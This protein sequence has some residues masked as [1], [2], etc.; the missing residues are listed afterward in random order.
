ML[1]LGSL[2]VPM[3]DR[4]PL[5]TSESARQLCAALDAGAATARISVD[6]GR[7]CIDV[8]IVDGEVR[9]G[10]AALNRA[11]LQKIVGSPNQ[12]F[13]I[14]AGH[15]RAVSVFSRTTGW[16]RSL[17]PTADAPT[18]VVAG[19]PMH[20]IQA[21]TPLADTRAKVRALG[22]ARALRGSVLDT[23]TGL[24][25]TAIELAKRSTEVVTVE[26]DPAA[27]ELAQRNP[28]S[29]DLFTAENIRLVV[30][31]I[32]QEVAHFADAQFHAVLHDPPTVQLA[33]ELYSRAFYM[34]LRRVLRPNGRLFHYVGDPASVAGSRA[35][36]G[37]MRR[38]AEA[39]FRSVRRV[40]R[41]FGVVAVAGAVNE[42][43][44]DPRKRNARRRR[45]G[46]G[47]R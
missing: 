9:L 18:T 22:A 14:V 28:W 10:D 31:D 24:G 7:S 33:G 2:W 11:P 20:R 26:L 40:S 13:E 43:A 34:Q 42:I 8:G 23:A 15:A 21:T 41:A 5:L 17:M 35:T 4:P 27:I 47:S 37:V 45:G 36:A 44:N 46:R 1:R 19:F 39:G 29:Q 38:L 3:R 12:C 30:G 6:L 32:A 16:V 25:Y